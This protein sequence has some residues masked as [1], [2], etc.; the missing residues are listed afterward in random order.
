MYV[1]ILDSWM[2]LEEGK[3]RR[4]HPMGR[5]SLQEMRLLT[6]E[7]LPMCRIKGKGM[8]LTFVTWCLII[9]RGSIIIVH[10]IRMG[11]L[12]GRE[13]RMI[14]LFITLLTIQSLSLVIHL[15]DNSFN[16]LC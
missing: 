3:V 13:L 1:V 9:F 15:P 8:M 11:I 16:F 12:E 10:L 2:F 7:G 4:L 5:R 6:L 14:K